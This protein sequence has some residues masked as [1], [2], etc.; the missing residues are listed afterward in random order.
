MLRRA[1]RRFL[2]RTPQPRSPAPQL[3]ST[4][5]SGDGLLAASESDSRRM[6]KSDCSSREHGEPRLGMLAWRRARAALGRDAPG[7]PLQGSRRLPRRGTRAWPRGPSTSQ[8]DRSTLP[9]HAS[10]SRGAG[11]RSLS[12]IHSKDPG[13][14]NRVARAGKIRFA[15]RDRG[16]RSSNLGDNLSTRRML[17]D[18]HPLQVGRIE[19]TPKVVRGPLRCTPSTAAAS[20]ARPHRAG[21]GKLHRVKHRTERQSA[22]A[23]LA[24]RNSTQADCRRNS[25]SRFAAPPVD[26]KSPRRPSSGVRPRYRAWILLLPGGHRPR[27]PRGRRPH[28]WL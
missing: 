27:S 26:L 23:A 22:T 13:L 18:H 25:P 15:Y 14:L 11:A 12:S 10:V 17:P 28:R 6:H 2:G 21:M 1:L 19:M 5:V 24:A 7:A 3:R 16:H 8:S 20:L 9:A 4:S